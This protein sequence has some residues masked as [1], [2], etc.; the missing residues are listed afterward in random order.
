MWLARHG[1]TEWTVDDKFNGW[2]DISLTELGKSQA[3]GLGLYFKERPLTVVYSSP[4]IRCLETAQSASLSHNLSPLIAPELKELDYGEWDGMARFDIMTE[5]PKTWAAWV[6]D[7]AGVA[8]PGGESGY[9]VLARITPFLKS[10]VA[11]YTGQE[12]LVVAHKAVNRLFL[13]DILGIPSRN[14]RKLIG[15][16][17]CALNCI[18]WIEGEPRV[19]LMNS[20]AHYSGL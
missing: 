20:I 18:Q 3:Q 11:Q 6:R 2:S 7:P 12:F 16:S 17:S 1:E 4:L 5:Y 14:Y 9:D 19:M 8:A 10:L 15:Q 13:C